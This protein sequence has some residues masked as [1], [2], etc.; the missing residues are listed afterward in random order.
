M[1]PI[2]AYRLGEYK[3][4]AD[5]YGDLRWEM[6][7]GF[8]S[9][10]VGRCFINGDI[11]FLQPSKM[12]KPGYLKGEFL[13]HLKKL[14][15]WRNTGFYCTSYRIHECEPVRGPAGEQD[16]QRSS[17]KAEAAEIRNDGTESEKPSYRLGRYEIVEAN[18]GRI[19]WKTFSGAG[20]VN[21]GTCH[22]SGDI[23]FIGPREADVAG[24]TKRQ[25]MQRRM[26]LPAWQKTQYYCPQYAMYHTRTGAL[27]RGSTEDRPAKIDAQR[28]HAADTT[29]TGRTAETDTGSVKNTRKKDY[30]MTAMA[31]GLLSIQLICKAVHGCLQIA[32]KLIRAAIGRWV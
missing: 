23:L 22:L 1:I 32:H 9:L 26:R 30:A 6:H 25:F 3:I 7:S 15:Q 17:D 11:L 16:N 14:P 20:G 18:H 12:T 2:G 31:V 10:K 13:D 27:W 29:S 8:G 24:L 19:S 28:R 4:T 21:A 5:T